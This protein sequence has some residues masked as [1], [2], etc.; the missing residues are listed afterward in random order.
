[1]ASSANIHE[2][3]SVSITMLS[4][5]FGVG[6]ELVRSRL[7][8]CKVMPVDVKNGNNLYRVGTA[9][10][11]ILLG[12]RADPDNMEPKELL[13]HYNAQRIKLK[14]MAE[15]KLLIDVESV[16][17]EYAALAKEFINTLDGMSDELEREV[18]MTPDQLNALEAKINNNR[19]MLYNRI[20]NR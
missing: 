11:A 12:N 20:K 3:L 14:L 1:M 13:D 18:D 4:M 5:E 10:R 15:E 7:S 17:S 8:K 19:L 2:G 6:R 16:R 9:A